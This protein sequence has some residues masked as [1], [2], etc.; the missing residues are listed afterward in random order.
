VPT[1]CRH[2]RF[3]E[4]CPICSRDLPGGGSS[5]T[6]GTRA[7]RSGATRSSG[8]RREARPRSDGLKVRRETRAT[9][10][11]YRSSLVPGLRASADGERL[12]DELGFANG[13]L[14]ALAA[15]PPGTYAMAA[16]EPDLEQGSWIALL[17]AY[18]SPLQAGDEASD[19]PDGDDPFRAIRGALTQWSAGEL[20]D[21]EAVQVGPRTSHDPA[22]GEETLLAYRQW[23]QRAGSQQAAFAGDAA[24]T[25]ERRFD[26]V[27]ERFALPGLTRGARFDLLVTLGRLGLY[28]LEPDSL[29]LVGDDEVTLA[30][31]RVFGIGDRPNLER[32]A[33]ALSEAAEVPLA[34]FDLA[35]AN[36][37]ANE[38]MTLGVTDAVADE[39]TAERARD[40]LDL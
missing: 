3:I 6:T 15:D 2:N 14:L 13:R 25:A 29:Q 28:E 39:D 31:K 8:A 24:W 36:W 30:A 40:A 37:A 23:A 38:R 27:Y 4:N 17:T 35:L 20:P 7:P 32:R 26:R 19:E 11:G 1:F 34:A 9:D 12:A 22:R 16:A 10:D 33:R 5:R 18:L 21:L